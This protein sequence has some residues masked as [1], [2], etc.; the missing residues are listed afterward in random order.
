M[1]DTRISKA[2]LLSLTEYFVLDKQSRVSWGRKKKKTPDGQF[3][4]AL[5]EEGRG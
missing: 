2:L 4:H 5:R 3:P 1:S